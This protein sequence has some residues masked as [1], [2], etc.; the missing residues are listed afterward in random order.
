[1]PADLHKPNEIRMTIHERLQHLIRLARLRFLV[2]SALFHTGWCFIDRRTDRW[3]DPQSLLQNLHRELQDVQKWNLGSG[4]L[5]VLKWVGLFRGG[6]QWLFSNRCLTSTV[7]SNS[8]ALFRKGRLPGEGR[9]VVTRGARL[10][11]VE[12]IPMDMRPGTSTLTAGSD[13][14]PVKKTIRFPGRWMMDAHTTKQE[15]RKSDVGEVRLSVLALT[16]FVL[17][18]LGTVVLCVPFFSW[19]AALLAYGLH[20]VFGISITLGAHRYF[21]HSTFQ[22][23]RWLERLL[24][25]GYTLSF[26]RCGEGLLSWVAGHKLHHAHT[27]RRLDPH[28]PEH[29]YWHAYCGHYIF[30]RRDLYE[31]PRYRELCR[32]WTEDPLLVWLNKTSTIVLLQGVLI[33]VLFALGGMVGPAEGFDFWMATSFVVWCVFVRYCLTQFLHSMV[34]TAGHGMW[35]FHRL[36]D[37]YGVNNRSKNNL[38]FWLLLGGNETWHNLHHA[39]PRAANNGERWYRWDLDSVIMKL[40]EKAGIISQLQWLTEEEMEHRRERAHDKGSDLGFGKLPNCADKGTIRDQ[41]KS[42]QTGEFS[43]QGEEKA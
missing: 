24:A 8:G 16:W 37:A 34:D 22:A 21:S 5:T 25:F 20:V 4:M 35:P 33:M 42:T 18:H 40:L 38:A 23:P 7:F 12:V 43:I 26:D 2:Y 13:H 29:G 32:E 27:D 28:S 9:C 17:T 31:F 10:E 41:R 1:M 14:C 36:P 30:R 6:M 15:H 19:Q 11:T 3:T 39:F